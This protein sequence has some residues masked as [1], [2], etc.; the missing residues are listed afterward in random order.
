[1]SHQS[2]KNDWRFHWRFLLSNHLG[3]F[4]ILAL[5]LVTHSAL[6]KNHGTFMIVIGQVMVEKD[7]NQLIPAM[8]GMKVSEGVTVITQANAQA[9]IVMHDRNIIRIG[10]NSRLKITSYQNDGVKKTAQFNLDQGQVR[11][12]VNEKYDGESNK[13]QISTPTAVAGVRGT[14][15]KVTFDVQ[16]RQTQIQTFKGLVAV[17]IPSGSADTLGGPISNPVLVPAGQATTVQQGNNDELII[18]APRPLL[19][20]ETKDFEQTTSN[21]KE[22]LKDGDAGTQQE[23]ENSQVPKN[24]NQTIKDKKEAKTSKFDTSNSNQASSRDPEAGDS[25]SSSTPGSSLE[26]PSSPDKPGKGDS[27]SRTP[28]DFKKPAGSVMIKDK[29]MVG[30][31]VG[32][33]LQQSRT[34]ASMTPPM[35]PDARLIANPIQQSPNLNIVNETIRDQIS[36]NN[37]KVKLNIE[38]KK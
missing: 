24:Q 10:P 33:G 15:F 37:K 32:G 27:M 18:E 6:G 17:S 26:P 38:I 8:V 35:T 19:P 1:M 36:N 21:Q 2:T 28:S 11:A 7:S 29:D 9:K 25:I 34:P 30:H 12:I 4:L 3:L 31:E 16:T 14:D 22:D 13:F 23:A 5:T 20:N